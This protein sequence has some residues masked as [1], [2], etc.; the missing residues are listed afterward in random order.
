MSYAEIMPA[1]AA[2]HIDPDWIDTL[3]P[4]ERDVL[5]WCSD[6]WLRPEQRVPAYDWS[7][8]GLDG[9][10]GFGK[11]YCLADDIDRRVEG[12][13][14]KL[15]ALMG[16]TEDRVYEV[17]VQSLIDY[18]PPWFR[19]VET[20]GG[21]VWP[22]GVR[23]VVFSAGAPERP[24]S[25]NISTAWCCE[26]VAWPE[27]TRKEAFANLRFATR[28]GRAQIMWD[29][30]SKGHN[31]LLAHLRQL[32]AR[33]PHTYPIVGGTS[34]DNVLIPNRVL[35]GWWAEQ[36]GVRRR[37][38]LFGEHFDEAQGALWKQAWLNRTRVTEA[39]HLEW[40]VICVDGATLKD[41]RSTSGK[42]DMFGI[43]RGGRAKDGHAYILEDMSGHYSP[44][45]WGDVVVNRC[46]RGGRVVVETNHVG[47]NAAYVIQSRAENS[48]LK[49]RVLDKDE[50]WPPLDPKC[51][52]IRETFSRE[53]KYARADAPAAE[54]EAGRVHLAGEFPDLEKELTTWVPG[55]T[56]SP[57][58]LDAL[59]FCV[60]ELR[61]LGLESSRRDVNAEAEAA[62]AVDKALRTAL[63][64]RPTA[65]GPGR[66]IGALAGRARRISR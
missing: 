22:N 25:E 40:E 48:G 46:L 57:N 19:P 1:L 49:V 65:S 51:I 12:G 27:S 30:T 9:G 16:P 54:T 32:N 7:I 45:E 26:L 35:R 28:V 4:A 42:V 10:R 36:T 44:S 62:A 33:D 47:D 64:V 31:D 3:T 39:P 41:S 14:E 18:S 43:V 55:A 23:A 56:R 58:R 2:S 61:E 66:L 60:S 8:F 38:E 5:P 11:S 29:S 15:I 53:G 13:G 59:A 17:Q 63:A 52:H 24:R 21:L 34:F 50:P 6:V 37:E 20:K